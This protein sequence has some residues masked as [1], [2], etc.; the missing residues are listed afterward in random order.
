[1]ATEPDRNDFATLLRT[2]DIVNEPSF[3]F[4]SSRNFTARSNENGGP[5]SMILPSRALRPLTQS[6]VRVTTLAQ[7]LIR[8]GWQPVWVLFAV[9]SQRRRINVVKK[10]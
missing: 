7:T 10:W 9:G 8:C 4:S 6:P 1:M 2:R 3:K 5:W